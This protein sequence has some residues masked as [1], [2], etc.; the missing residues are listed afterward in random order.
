MQ[1]MKKIY[2][3]RRDMNKDREEVVIETGDKI[4]EIPVEKII[5]KILHNI[6]MKADDKKGHENAE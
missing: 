1:T 3:V 6:I 4:E 5:S 2:R